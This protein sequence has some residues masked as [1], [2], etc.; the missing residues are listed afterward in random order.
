MLRRVFK[1]S[2]DNVTTNSKIVDMNKTQSTIQVRVDKKTK[3][4]AKKTL[5]EMGLDISSA[6]KL[7]LNNVVIT[8][9][10]PFKIRTRNGFTQEEERQMRKEIDEAIKYGKRYK[11]ADEMMDNIL[12]KK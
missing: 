1:I 6:V 8:Q 9:S 10:I 12:S 3:K 11:N 7:F 2:I 5:G 4:D